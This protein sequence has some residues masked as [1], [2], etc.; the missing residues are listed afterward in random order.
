MYMYRVQ[1]DWNWIFKT[2][3]ICPS[4]FVCGCWH[5]VML[6]K[7]MYLC[8]FKHQNLLHLPKWFLRVCFGY[9]KSVWIFYKLLFLK[10]WLLNNVRMYSIQ[11]WIFPESYTK[12]ISTSDVLVFPLTEWRSLYCNPQCKVIC[13]C[14]DRMVIISASLFAGRS[15]A[16]VC[17]NVMS[18][19]T[20][21]TVL[22][23]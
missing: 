16:V 22:H 12:T 18:P 8:K 5:A 21:A 4:I 1:K 11:N 14:F 7:T 15:W 23:V 17:T 19:V 13:I 20:V 6:K 9:F 2:S 10:L 3:N